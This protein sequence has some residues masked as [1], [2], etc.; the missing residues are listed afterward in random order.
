MISIRVLAAI[1]LAMVA[2]SAS[3]EEVSSEDRFALWDAC[4]PI[5]YEV[6]LQQEATA[7]TRLTVEK[8][9]TIVQRSLQVVRLLDDKNA[10]FGASLLV[11][12][13]VSGFSVHYVRVYFRKLVK[14]IGSGGIGIA[15]TWSHGMVRLSRGSDGDN[16]IKSTISEIMDLFI[17]E[18]LRVNADAC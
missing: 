17:D 14:A 2:V 8:V 4:Q 15:V 13:T 10:S 18:Y 12:V 11:T 16:Q 3:A 1:V 9:E 5:R 7:N 6:D